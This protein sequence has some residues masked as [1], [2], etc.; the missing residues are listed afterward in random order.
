[1][2]RRL[3]RTCKRFRAQ[4]RPAH[5]EKCMLLRFWEPNPDHPDEPRGNAWLS[6]FTDAESDAMHAQAAAATDYQNGD[7]P[8]CAAHI[9]VKR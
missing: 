5:S 3:C 2:S 6:V 1:M 4:P 9:E 8:G 7:A